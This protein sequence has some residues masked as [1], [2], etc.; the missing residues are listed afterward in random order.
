MNKQLLKRSIGLFWIFAIS[1]SLF[2]S[3]GTQSGEMRIQYLTDGLVYIDAGSD[4]G[5]K[6][7]DILHVMDGDRRK[8]EIKV[9]NISSKS[10]ACTLLGENRELNVGDLV[11]PAS[12]VRKEDVK[13]VNQTRQRNFENRQYSTGARERKSGLRGSISLQTYNYYDQTDAGRDF[14]RPGLRINL[15]GTNLWGRGLDFRIRTR[16]RYIVRDQPVGSLRPESEWKNRVYQASIGKTQPESRLN[17]QVGRLV[18]NPISG[19]GY[20]DG[21]LLQLRMTKG[22]HVGVFAGL[23]PEWQHSDLQTSLTKYGLYY[24]FEKGS[25]RAGGLESTVAIAGEYHGGTV[26]RELL[27]LRNRFNSKGK[28]T[29]YQSAEIEINRDWR[30][31]KTGESLQL[32][33]LHLYGRYRFTD[34]VDL[35]LT[36]DDR[37]LYYT[38][39]LR[40]RDEQFF[41]DL[42]RQGVRANLG[43]RINRDLSLNA[44]Y[45]M[46][47]R[48]GDEDAD[49]YL[50]NL[51]HRNFF[52][53]GLSLNLRVN[54]F[55]NNLT[56]GT[57]PAIRIGKRFGTLGNTLYLGYSTYDYRFT[58]QPDRHSEW[59]RLEGY[60]VLSR[61]F[62][63]SPQLEYNSG[64]DAEGYRIFLDLGYRL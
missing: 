27:Y 42:A 39:E 38:Y 63:L 32:S 24:H 52:L 1:S 57:S 26:N 49:Y 10:A 19:V 16:T 45:G 43:W 64:D 34:G 15:R 41:D 4:A 60:F 17:W 55:S 37:K 22:S 59:I 14:Q 2:H 58:D 6:V 20:I 11:V 33:N 9:A 25:P 29:L 40:N 8:A 30:K 18:A 31:E 7:G 3:L 36:Y 28:F 21:G 35:G 54:G 61:G 44:N 51:F 5:L 13:P 50:I 48:E 53:K 56:E 46:R 47:S 62:F 23:Q 12:P